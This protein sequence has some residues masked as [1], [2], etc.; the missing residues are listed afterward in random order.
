MMQ[1]AIT[2]KRPDR[3][4]DYP[5]FIQ[6]IN[7]ASDWCTKNIIDHWGVDGTTFMFSYAEDLSAFKQQFGIRE[8]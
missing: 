3:R 5:A 1:H 4:E 2:M 8:L 7:E 6:K